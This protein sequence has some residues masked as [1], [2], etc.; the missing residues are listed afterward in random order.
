MTASFYVGQCYCHCYYGNFYNFNVADRAHVIDCLP[1]VWSLDGKL[2]TCKYV[3][4]D[5]YSFVFFIS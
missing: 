1:N 4:E 5:F 3:D 2:I